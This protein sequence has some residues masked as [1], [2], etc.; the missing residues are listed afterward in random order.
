MK[1]LV[2]NASGFF[3]TAKVFLAAIPGIVLQIH[4]MCYFK[5]VE[6]QVSLW[7]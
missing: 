6:N 1:P 5:P 4:D 7:H 3:F 2:F